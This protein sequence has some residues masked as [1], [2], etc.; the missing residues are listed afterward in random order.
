MLW[1]CHS[2]PAEASLDRKA[3]QSGLRRRISG[4][5]SQLVIWKIDT[6]M[7]AVPGCHENN[8]NSCI[9]R[10]RQSIQ[11]RENSHK[12]VPA[13]GASYLSITEGLFSFC[14]RIICSQH[15]ILAKYR[16]KGK[17]R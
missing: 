9:E 5:A 8:A 17:P 6:V 10:I 3:S 15:E 14:I 2:R 12:I 4:A 7:P 13:P 16:K 11:H 1:F